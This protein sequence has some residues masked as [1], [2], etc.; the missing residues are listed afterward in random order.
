MKKK[1]TIIAFLIIANIPKTKA[2]G[3]P[4][5]LTY[6]NSIVANKN[7]YIGQ[8]FSLLKNNLQIEIKYFQS[9]AA[10]HYNKDRETSTSFAFYFPNDADEIY[11]TF[12]KLEI[13][14]QTPLNINQSGLL[15]GNNNG[16]GWSTAVYNFYKNAIIADIKVRE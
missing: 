14:W 12:P 6:L 16:G 9:F 15:W 2:Q 4:D 5:T 13:Y 3:V 7:N 1:L 8:S 11:L 10:I